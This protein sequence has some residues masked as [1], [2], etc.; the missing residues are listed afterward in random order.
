[1]RAEYELRR[2]TLKTLQR[3]TALLLCLGMVFAVTVQKAAAYS[4]QP[5]ST[6]TSIGGGYDAEQPMEDGAN[7]TKLAPE[8]MIGEPMQGNGSPLF[9]WVI[10]AIA[11]LTFSAVMATREK[12]RDKCGE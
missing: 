2:R 12:R 7:A 5:A 8:Q 1:M 10:I 4:T 11:S 9:V 6:G 3:V